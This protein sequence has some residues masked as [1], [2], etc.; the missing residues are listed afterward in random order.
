MRHRFRVYREAPNDQ[1]AAPAPA[2]EA[3]PA[4]QEE[5]LDLAAVLNYDFTKDEKPAGN[6]AAVANEGVPA[7]GTSGSQPAD[8]SIVTPTEG[9]DPIEALR[10]ANAP[11]AETGNDVVSKALDL[12]R[13]QQQTPA[14]PAGQPAAQQPAEGE[15]NYNM[16]IPEKIMSAIGSEDPEER[17][18]GINALSQ[19]LAVTIHRQVTEN[20]NKALE[21]RFAAIPDMIKNSQTEG[22]QRQNIFGDFYGSHPEL[23]TPTMKPLV[24]QAV[25]KVAQATGVTSYTPQ[26]KAAIVEQVKRDLAAYVAA[27][28]GGV[29]PVAAP[30]PAPVAPAGQGLMGGGNTRSYEGVNSFESEM[31]MMMKLG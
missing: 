18:A 4:A 11:A 31:D 6:D 27:A 30:A 22:V 23:N 16:Q 9:A 5:E 10:A 13:A 7:D 19:G 14:A 8:A 29:P 26:F 3:A 12:L 28:N 1:G 25:Q 21:A 24:L 17:A 20:F 15:P 2:A